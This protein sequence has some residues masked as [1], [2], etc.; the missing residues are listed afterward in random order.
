M[1]TPLAVS[2]AKLVL[3]L[4]SA[5]MA[6]DQRASAEPPQFLVTVLGS[7]GSASYGCGINASGQ[8]AGWTETGSYQYAV[9]WTGTT[10]EV[11]NDIGG[12]YGGHSYA[13]GINAS[14]QVVG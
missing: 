10:P 3:F 11:L 14:G 7:V 8:I 2:L 6:F 4:G 9:R 1:K 12:N 13:F 5:F